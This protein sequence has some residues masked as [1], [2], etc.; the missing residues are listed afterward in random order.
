MSMCAKFAVAVAVLSMTSF[1]PCASADKLSL[2]R[3][4]HIVIGDGAPP[5]SLNVRLC[6]AFA[7]KAPVSISL[8][9]GAKKAGNKKHDDIH[10]TAQ[11]LHYKSCQDWPLNLQRGDT[12]EFQQGGAQLGAF[13]VT[14]VPQWDATLLLIIKRKGTSSRAVFASHVFG[15]TKNAQLAVLDM[16]TGPSKHTVVIQE[17]KEPKQPSPDESG[18]QLLQKRSQ[19]ENLA[20]DTVVAVGDGSYFCSLAEIDQAKRSTYAASTAEKKSKVAF[21]V[22]AAENYVALRVG[23]SPGYPEELIVFPSSES[24]RVGCLSVTMLA[25][26]LLSLLLG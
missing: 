15:K 21:N 1:I 25:A 19:S 17:S 7:D 6:N 24:Y 3:S 9:P 12:F 20:Y 14:S 11:G 23:G 5:T 8:K 18:H 2:Q 13:A 26:A 10:L 22:V 4:K 16:Y